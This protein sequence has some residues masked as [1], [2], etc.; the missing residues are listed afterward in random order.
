MLSK[1]MNNITYKTG[2]I[3][4]EVVF[5]SLFRQIKHLNLFT[6]NPILKCPLFSQVEMSPLGEEKQG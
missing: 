3:M 5:L 6:V 1:R 2:F 4:G